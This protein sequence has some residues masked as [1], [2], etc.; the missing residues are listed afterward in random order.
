MQRDSCWG[1]N[2]RQPPIPH[3]ILRHALD[4]I[5]ERALDGEHRSC[6]V[7]KLISDQVLVWKV[8]HPEVSSGKEVIVQRRVRQSWTTEELLVDST[9]QFIGCGT[10]DV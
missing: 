9:R 1:A 10:P 4:N 5:N 7:L 2:Y 3:A 8:A 6:K